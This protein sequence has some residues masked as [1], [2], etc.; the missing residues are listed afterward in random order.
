MH[1]ISCILGD[2]KSWFV[3]FNLELGGLWEIPKSGFV[4]VILDHVSKV[5]LDCP[6]QERIQIYGIR[7]KNI[8]I[9]KQINT[10][11][12]FL[13]ELYQI[14]SWLEWLPEKSEEI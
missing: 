7:L 4:V 6:V 5:N 14:L 8:C 13:C 9:N 3:D 12:L 10:S 11:R 2:I 1:V